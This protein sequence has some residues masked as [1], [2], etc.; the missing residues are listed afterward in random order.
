MTVVQLHNNYTDAGP[1]MI[2]WTRFTS[3]AAN[4]FTT[5][6]Q[7]LGELCQHL[8]DAGPFRDKE[9]CPWIKLATFGDKRTA[10]GAL[11][12]DANVLAIT[13]VEGDYDGGVIQPQQAVEMLERHNIRAIVYTSPSHRPHAPRWRVLAPLSGPM[14]P[15]VRN[16]LLARVNGALGG[17]LAHES[18]TLSQSYFYGEVLGSE[19]RV[20]LTF[21]DPEE[22]LCVDELDNLDEIA[23]GPRQKSVE[24]GA[25]SPRI[26][27]AIFADAVA[28][29]GRLLKTG[30]GRRELLKQ[31]IA[32]RSARGMSAP[33]IRALVTSVVNEYFDPND[34]PDARDLNDLIEHF[35]RRDGPGAVVTD[36]APMLSKLHTVPT[37]V[38]PETGE[39]LPE[40]EERPLF[41]QVSDL[42]GDIKPIQWLVDGYLEQDALSM[43]YGPSGGGKSFV[44]VDIACS[45][46]TGTPWH[47]AK[48]TQGAVFYIAGEG[49]NGLSRRFAAWQKARGVPL[50]STVPIYKS[51]RAVMMLDAGAA[52]IMSNEVERLAVA[53]GHKPAL[54]IIDTLARNFGDGD[55]N[56][57][58]DAGR[59]IEHM[60]AYIRRRWGCNVMVV[61]HSGHDSDRARGSSAF[62][63]AMDQEIWIKGAG[64][65]IEMNMTKMK[66]ADTPSPKLF[67]ITETGLGV[68]DDCDVEIMGAFLKIDGDPLLFKVGLRTNGSEITAKDVVKSMHKGWPG[69]IPMA[70][71]LGCS[72]RSLNRIMKAMKDNGMADSYNRGAT[73]KGWELSEKALNEFSQG[74]GIL[75]NKGD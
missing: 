41:T 43:V 58:K 30:D 34:Q 66:D 21:N 46:A 53:T 36:M 57:Q 24:P 26:E 16:L 74:G 18:F 23:V 64:G 49:H 5:N 8:A 35:G 70:A 33:E 47:G 51:N 50:N 40:E 62:K 32:S 75:L 61:H 6:T 65:K 59:F 22:A 9:S 28:E 38:D 71:E 39:V 60:D 17:I 29:K 3:R 68:R 63:G 44:V 20:Y 1:G 10:K 15:D 19:Y 27:I 52:L 37:K 4:V 25:A 72:E 11:R 42:L 2:E 69:A 48:T 14:T 7:S 54:V 67:A 73:N 56:T 55:E 31:Y 13:G 45:I 12:H